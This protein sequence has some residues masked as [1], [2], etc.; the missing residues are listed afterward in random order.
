[1]SETRPVQLV[2]AYDLSPS[3]EVALHRAVEVVARAPHHVLH[4]VTVLDSHAG[5]HK[6]SYDRAEEMQRTLRDH[7]AAAFGNRPTTSE[8]QFFIHCRIGRPV[9]EIL[10]LAYE[11]GADLIFVGSHNKASLERMLLGSVSERV[12]RE[13]H[14]PV[15][16][17]RPKTYRDVDL[18]KVVFYE[19]PHP[20]YTPP[21][22]YSYIE[23]RVIA[24]PPDWPL[25]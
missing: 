16:V 1:V 12:V 2:V 9:E 20:N 15:M 4:V 23:T 5:V 25:N 19:H 13:A 7:V 17:A 22:R 18:M 3:G 14:C 11:V 10:S 24:R 21:H 8:V 6:V